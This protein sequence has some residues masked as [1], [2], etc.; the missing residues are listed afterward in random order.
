MKKTLFPTLFILFSILAC[1][2]LED[3][4]PID[5]L[6]KEIAQLK[7]MHRQGLY[8]ASSNLKKN[9]IVKSSDEFI[10]NEKGLVVNILQGLNGSSFSTQDDFIHSFAEAYGKINLMLHSPFKKSGN[11]EDLDLRQFSFYNANQLSLVQ[12]Y[13]DELLEI[14]DVGKARILSTKFQDKVVASPLRTEDKLVLL[15]VSSSMIALTEFIEEGGDKQ[16]NNILQE[17]YNTQGSKSFAR[18]KGCGVNWKSVWAGAIIGG[19][20]GAAGGCYAGATAGTVTVPVVGTVTGCVSAGVVGGA[21]GFLSGALEGIASEL[22]TS[23][24]R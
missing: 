7:T 3:L 24:F 15:S 14:E 22:L 13:V 6:F 5:K 2:Q 12:P 23:C 21:G 4:T 10:L 9:L 8:L 19:A 11:V 1:N 17:L 18:N 16:I 20:V